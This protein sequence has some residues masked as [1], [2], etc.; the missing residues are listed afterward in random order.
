MGRAGVGVDERIGIYATA[1]IFLDTPIGYTFQIREGQKKKR[2]E[3]SSFP[4]FFF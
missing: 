4:A 1:C 3:G 2:K